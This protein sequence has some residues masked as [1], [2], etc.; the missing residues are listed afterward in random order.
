M[1]VNVDKA[2]VVKHVKFV[3]YTGKW[4]NLCGGILTLEIDG[5]IVRFGNVY[6]GK[7]VDYEKFWIPGGECTM[8]T[9]HTDEWGIDVAQLPLEFREYAA[10]IDAVFNANVEQGHC[11][12]CR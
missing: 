1:L 6:E 3:R 10:E 4:P 9:L 5:K 8:K 12:G 7:E 2:D 11:G